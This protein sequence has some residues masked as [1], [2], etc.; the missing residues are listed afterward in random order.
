MDGTANSYIITV[1]MQTQTARS[2]KK[3]LHITLT[4]LQIRKANLLLFIRIGIKLC[5]SF[6]EMF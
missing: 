2:L 4:L 1:Y 3:Y 6:A 5:V